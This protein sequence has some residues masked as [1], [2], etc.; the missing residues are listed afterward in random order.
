ME[1]ARIWVV[2]DDSSL[3]Y[4]FNARIGVVSVVSVFELIIVSTFSHRILIL[5]NEIIENGLISRYIIYISYIR[6]MDSGMFFSILGG[7]LDFVYIQRN[8][9]RLRVWCMLFLDQIKSDI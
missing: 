1:P 6:F 3:L 7:G 8:V 9:V 4:R 5:W 2:P